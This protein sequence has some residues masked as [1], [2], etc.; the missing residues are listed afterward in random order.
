[1][2]DIKTI[3][4]LSKAVHEIRDTHAV[5][6][7]KLHNQYEKEE[8]T[9]D[10]LKVLLLNEL[11]SCLEKI[12]ALTLKALKKLYKIKNNEV[13]KLE[14]LIYSE[15]GKTIEERLD[16]Y[17]IEKKGLH[18]KTNLIRLIDTESEYVFSGVMED[19]IDPEL[20]P[21]FRVDNLDEDDCGCP[22]PGTIFPMSAEKPPY[23]PECECTWEPLTQE[24][25][26]KENLN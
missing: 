14:D 2:Q 23:H 7:I 5:N 4:D 20:Y 10:E 25:Y 11:Y 1:M 8:L 22:A 13:L 26:E 3:K 16:S 17:Y 18:A 15:D 9:Y 21:Y 12:V 19:K 6:L 24:E